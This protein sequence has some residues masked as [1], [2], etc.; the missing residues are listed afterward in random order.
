MKPHIYIQNPIIKTAKFI[1]FDQIDNFS[2]LKRHKI[3]KVCIEE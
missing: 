1:V 3:V 2:K